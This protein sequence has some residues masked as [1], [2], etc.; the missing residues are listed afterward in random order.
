VNLAAV[1]HR[2]IA[3][4][5]E[6][7]RPVLLVVDGREVLAYEGESVAAALLATGQRALHTAPRRAEPRGMYCGIGLCF[8]CAVTV[9]G[10]PGVRACLTPVRDG[11]AVT[12]AASRGV[13]GA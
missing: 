13:T 1:D 9:D 12:T 6:R 8:E 11:L 10:R 4:A 5:V 2:R 7:G 3:S